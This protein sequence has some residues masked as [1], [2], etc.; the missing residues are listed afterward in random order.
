MTDCAHTHIKCQ[1][2]FR[3]IEPDKLLGP[4]PLQEALVRIQELEA[5]KLEAEIAEIQSKTAENYAEAELDQAKAKETRSNADLKDLDYVEQETGTK[6][7]R[8]VDKIT[9]QAKAQTDKSIIEKS[10]DIRAEQNKEDRE[11]SKSEE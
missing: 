4:P 1:E 3:D 11:A 8:D 5:I 7:A 10:I 2:C 9:S 6:H